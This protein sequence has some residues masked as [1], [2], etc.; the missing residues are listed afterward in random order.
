MTLTLVTC[1]YIPLLSASQKSIVLTFSHVKAYVSKIDLA[2]KLV[3]FI[4]GSS[5]EQTMMN[6][7]PQC[8]IP[9][10]MEIG[11]PVLEMKIFEGFLP[12]IGMAAILVM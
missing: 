2:V 4:P 1:N 10:F 5:I 9:S 6:W 3:K 7:S 11:P 8:Y 12:C